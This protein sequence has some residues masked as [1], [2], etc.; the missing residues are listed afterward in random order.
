MSH[1]ELPPDLEPVQR[2][3]RRLEQFT[4]AY[5]VT[6][7]IAVGLTLGSSQA[8][9]AAW[10]EDL[11]SLFP[12][13]AFLVAARVRRRDPNPRYPW[14]Y[15]RAVTI[16]Y[17]VASLALLMMG[18]LILWDS[19]SR[20]AKSEHP[21]IG[22]VE[23]FGW[24]VWAGWLMIAALLYS[25]IPPVFLG[26]MKLELADALHDKVL[27]ADAQMNKADWMTAGAAILGILGIGVGLWWADA[28]AATII[29]V[30]I[31]HDGWTN[32]RRSVRD[33]MDGRVSKHDADEAHPCIGAVT[34]ALQELDW[35]QD[36]RVRL[37]EDGHVFS[38]EAF[39]VMRD[40][41]DVLERL[42]Q[43]HGIVMDQDFKMH[44]I[45][46]VP[47]REL[48]AREPEATAQLATS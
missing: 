32:L 47:V 41:R 26:R 34:R 14:G 21:P 46:I 8:M 20:L 19:V 9:K 17:Q 6:A 2:K 30:D 3:A 35:V 27:Y 48:G 15:H 42:E 33:L 29:S 45:V 37:R 39:V 16:G 18:L 1:W 24:E 31:V 4:L 44:D 13:I 36:V 23:V 10:V 22:L 12:P 11:L 43:A 7:L 28:V 25:G 38:G 40:E 5:M